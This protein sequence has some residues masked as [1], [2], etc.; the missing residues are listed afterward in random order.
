MA[1]YMAVQHMQANM[2]QVLLF[3]ESKICSDKFWR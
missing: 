2:N 3:S 1:I